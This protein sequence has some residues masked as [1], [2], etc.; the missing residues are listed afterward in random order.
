MILAWFLELSNNCCL[1]SFDSSEVGIFLVTACHDQVMMCLYLFLVTDAS[2]N[3]GPAGS[4]YKIQ[5]CLFDQ[6][7]T[8]S[9]AS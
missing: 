5:M 8:S 3:L 9:M 4:R 7:Y 1:Q 2:E 6:N